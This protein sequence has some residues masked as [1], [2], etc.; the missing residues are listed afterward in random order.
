MRRKPNPE[1]RRRE[2]CDTAIR[3]LAEDGLKGVSHLKVDRRA[4]VPD[5]TT[6]FYF[7]TRSALIHAVAARVAELDRKDLTAATRERAENVGS[8]RRSPSGLAKLVI[9]ASSGA[10]LTRTKARSELALQAPRDPELD[11]AFRGYTEGFLAIIK[12]AVERAQASRGKTD[13]ALVDE[14]AHVVMMFLS[15]LMLSFAS[16]V[17][18]TYTAED[19]DRVI[20]AIVDGMHTSFGSRNPGQG[21]APT[22]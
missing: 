22:G 8:Q 14:Q 12:D 3:L 4:G 5:G 6:S 21:A 11:E 2:L 19:V 18:R 16:G 13:P 20:S 7:R 15:G 1:Q 10:R 17:R 9:S